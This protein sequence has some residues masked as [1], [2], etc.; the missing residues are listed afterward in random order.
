MTDDKSFS[1]KRKTLWKKKMYW[2]I[3]TELGSKKILPR[4]VTFWTNWVDVWLSSSDVLWKMNVEL[5]LLSWM[6]LPMNIPTSL[7][8]A[9]SV[10]PSVIEVEINSFDG[11]IDNVS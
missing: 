9:V 1:K 11:L 5:N 3:E 7:G 2:K 6:F 8:L 10:C 4:C